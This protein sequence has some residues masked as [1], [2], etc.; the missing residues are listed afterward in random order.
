[1]QVTAGKEDR[2]AAS[3][4]AKAT[5]FTEMRKRRTDARESTRV[6]NARIVRPIGQAVRF[7]LARAALTV[8]KRPDRIGVSPGEVLTTIASQVNRG[9]LVNDESSDVSGHQVPSRWSAQRTGL[10]QG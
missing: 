10:S 7:A 5:L 4:A 3:A 6:T 9:E 8:L 1:M 2:A